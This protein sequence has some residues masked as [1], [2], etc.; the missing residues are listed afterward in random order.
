MGWLSL[1]GALISWSTSCRPS[2][3]GNCWFHYLSSHSYILWD[4]FLRVRVMS[5]STLCVASIY[6]CRD[7]DTVLFSMHFEMTPNLILFFPHRSAISAL[8]LMSHGTPGCSETPSACL[9]TL[10]QFLFCGRM[11]QGSCNPTFM[12]WLWNML[13]EQEQRHASH[14]S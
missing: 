2:S 8:P 6:Q 7:Q 3:S 14:K 13:H 1:L 5:D 12:H 11:D 9:P 4:I 10:L